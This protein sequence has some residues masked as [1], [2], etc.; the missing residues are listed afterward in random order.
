MKV[1]FLQKQEIQLDINKTIS[2]NLVI[3]DS[4]D[5]QIMINPKNRKIITFPKETFSDGNENRQLEFFNFLLRQSAVKHDSVQ[6]GFV[7]GSYDAL[8]PEGEEENSLNY[9]LYCIS[10]FFKVKIPELKKEEEYAEKRRE[11][12]LEPDDEHSTDLGDVP[13][14]ER[15]GS[16]HH[17][18]R[19]NYTYSYYLYE[20]KGQSGMKIKQEDLHKIIKEEYKEAKRLG[21]ILNTNILLEAYIDGKD[22]SERFAMIRSLANEPKKGYNIIKAYRIIEFFDDEKL[23][24][25]AFKYFKEHFGVVG[26]RIA[27]YVTLPNASPLSL[28]GKDLTGYDLS[29]L[30]LSKADFTGANLSGADLSGADLSK[31][32]LSGAN[33]SGADL[34]GASLFKA[35]LSGAKLES[36]DLSEAKLKGVDFSGIDLNNVNLSGANLNGVNLR[37]AKF[38]LGNVTLK[39]ANLS[40]VNLSELDLSNFDLSGTKLESADLSGANLSGADLSG[41]DLSRVY[42]LGA[43]FTNAILDDVYMITRE[44]YLQGIK[45]TGAKYNEKTIIGAAS[46]KKLQI[47]RPENDRVAQE[48]G[49]VSSKKNLNEYKEAKR[50]GW[51][52][53]EEQ[54][55]SEEEPK[56]S[57][58]E[59]AQIGK[60]YA[61]NDLSQIENLGQ[62]T[63]YLMKE[64]E[65]LSSKIKKLFSNKLNREILKSGISVIT[66]FLL[67]PFGAF[68]GAI[69][70]EVLSRAISKGL[71]DFQVPDE[72]RSQAAVYKLFDL[73]DELKALIVGHIKDTEMEPLVKD[74]LLRYIKEQQ[75]GDREDWADIKI[76]D[77]VEKMNASKIQWWHSNKFYQISKEGNEPNVA[78]ILTKK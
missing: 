38:K 60:N 14:E 17:D 49:M 47:V 37:E 68:K 75:I 69:A 64:D 4:P 44:D 40:N 35:N 56:V 62:L 52:L 63:Y 29:G 23:Y 22:D 39:G 73:D 50:L 61:V 30:P 16:I 74:F 57:E 10:E 54:E 13:H 72:N 78:K 42:A 26:I 58:E 66:G 34:S 12:I 48:R 18:L 24:D 65:K 27:N 31:V 59:A 45:L 28:K 5:Y 15:K 25:M 46:W 76:A 7:F 71:D 21:W 70:A 6:S 9:L 41:A 3:D 43:D 19:P 2:G 8:Y 77:F 33:L 53:K 67:G 20:G 1:K 11:F 32:N 55:V 51:V 36:A